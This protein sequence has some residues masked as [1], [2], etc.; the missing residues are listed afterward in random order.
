MPRSRA[1]RHAVLAALITALGLGAALPGGAPAATSSTSSAKAKM[2]AAK[3]RSTRATIKNDLWA[4]VNICD[5]DEHPDT[6][7]IRGSM[8]GSGKSRE[9][10]YMRFQLQYFDQQ[11]KEWHNIGASGDSD[12][13]PVGSASKRR[14]R[15]SGRNFTVRPPRTGAFYLRGAVTFEWRRGTKVTRRHRKRTTSKHPGTAGADPVGF[16]AGKCILR[17][18]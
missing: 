4:T 6:I 14:A 1:T 12:F 8:P 9:R 10:M 17:A 16:S 5:T 7:G 2:A 18:G 3:M 13:V 15:E 11:E